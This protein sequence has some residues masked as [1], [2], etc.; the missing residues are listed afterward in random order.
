MILEGDIEQLFSLRQI[1]K[2]AIYGA[3]ASLT[4][5]WK[6]PFLISSGSAETAEILN[7]IARREQLEQKKAVS[8][9]GESKPKSFQE[10]QEFFI[11]GLPAVGPNLAK[12]L[13]EHFKTPKA[14]ANASEEDLTKVEGLGDK[15]AKIIK[16]LLDSSYSKN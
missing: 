4:L 9:R 16:R 13:L 1:N 5:D 10:M 8:I 11:E 2:N 12:R 14:I 3:L 6:I 15:K 7:A